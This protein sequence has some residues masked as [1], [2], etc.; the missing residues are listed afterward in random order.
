MSSTKVS[1][2]V[3]SLSRRC[4]VDTDV[5]LECTELLDDRFTHSINLYGMS[6][7]KWPEKDS[8]FFKFQWPS[9][10]ALRDTAQVVKRAGETH[11]GFGFTLAKNGAGALWVDTKNSLFSTLALV[12]DPVVRILGTDVW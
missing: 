9:P 4:D 10:A 12:D 7:R 8:V 1:A 6:M 2:F 3:S 11:S 5:S